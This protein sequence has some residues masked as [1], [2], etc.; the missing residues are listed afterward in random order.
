MFYL[1]LRASMKF[2]HANSCFRIASE[3]LGSHEGGPAP[4]GMWKRSSMAHLVTPRQIMAGS[5]ACSVTQMWSA[6]WRKWDT[7]ASQKGAAVARRHKRECRPRI[8]FEV[9][10][11]SR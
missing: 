10:K 2:P 7:T 9:K 8:T 5:A 1:P 11:K 3:C 6:I 4:Y